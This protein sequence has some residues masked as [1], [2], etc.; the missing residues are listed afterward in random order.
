MTSLIF[1]LKKNIDETRNYLLYEIKHNDLMSEKHKKV[2][3]DFNYLEHFF[4]FIS[5]V[6]K[7]LSVSSFASLVSIS[8]G[9]ASPAVGLKYVLSLDELKNI[10]QLSK[11][12]EEE[13]CYYIC[14]FS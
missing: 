14:Y 8:V 12:K 1:R 4:L 7:C 3:R 10:R 9:I 5:I 6:T 13:A 11:K 2:C